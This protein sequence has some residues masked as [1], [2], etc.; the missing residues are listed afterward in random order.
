[1]EAAEAGFLVRLVRSNGI[2]RVLC[3]RAAGVTG[4]SPLIVR[5]MP[6][7]AAGVFLR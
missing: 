3:G 5:M 6:I 4:A 2:R 7:S 1:M